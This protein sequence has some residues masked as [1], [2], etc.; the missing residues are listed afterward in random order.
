LPR[1]TAIAAYEHSFYTYEKERDMKAKRFLSVILVLIMASNMVTAVGFGNVGANNLFATDSQAYY[2]DESSGNEESMSLDSDEYDDKT[3]VD[4]EAESTEGYDTD[5]HPTSELPDDEYELPQSDDDCLYG[6]E[7]GY[8]LGLLPEC[9]CEPDDYEYIYSEFEHE[10]LRGLVTAPAR[11][12]FRPFFVYEGDTQQIIIT[13][14]N[15][16]NYFDLNQRIG[17]G[18]GGEL[19]FD[20]ETGSVTLTQDIV[21][22]VGSTTLAPRLMMTSPFRLEGEVY[23]GTRDQHTGQT[24]RGADGIGFAFHPN[25]TRALGAIGGALGIGGLPNGIGFKLDTWHNSGTPANGYLA[26]PTRFAPVAATNLAIRNAPHP[27]FDTGSLTHPSGRDQRDGRAFGAFVA[28][29]SIAFTCQTGRSMIG[30]AMV[31]DPAEGSP[32][33]A[34]GLGDVTRDSIGDWRSDNWHSI[35]IDYD[36]VNGRNIMSVY[37]ANINNPQV[38]LDQTGFANLDTFTHSWVMDITDIV[39]ASIASGVASWGLSISASTGGSRNFHGFRIR[40]VDYES[41][42]G[43]LAE[44]YFRDDDGSDEGS[45]EA[46]VLYPTITHDNVPED[47]MV[48]FAFPEREAS[49]N[50]RGY[51]FSRLNYSYNRGAPVYISGV[52]VLQPG[53]LYAEAGFP[54]YYHFHPLYNPNDINSPFERMNFNARSQPHATGTFTYYFRRAHGTITVVVT[55]TEGNVINDTFEFELRDSDGNVVLDL[56]D[57][58]IILI[59]GADGTITTPSLPTG[60]FRLYPVSQP[61]RWQIQNVPPGAID[62]SV[63]FDPLVHN[64]GGQN[65]EPNDP[66]PE[67]NV[68]VNLEYGISAPTITV[69][70][71]SDS[72]D[73]DDGVYI[74]PD[75]V[76][77]NPYEP[78][79]SVITW[80]LR[81]EDGNLV[82]QG[83]GAEIPQEVLNNLPIGDYNVRFTEVTDDGTTIYDDGEFR[84]ERDMSISIDRPISPREITADRAHPDSTISWTITTPDGIYVVSGPGDRVPSDILSNLPNGDY[85][86]AFVEITPGVDHDGTR[87]LESGD[88]I[89]RDDIFTIGRIVVEVDRPVNPGNVNAIPVYPE[90]ESTISWVIRGA[91]G[92]EVA[93]G[94]GYRIPADVLNNLLDGDYEAEFTERGLNNSEHVDT[95]I[96]SVERELSPISTP[97]PTSSPTPTPSPTPMPT[98]TPTPSSTPTPYPTH[99]PSHNSNATLTHSSTPTPRA[100]LPEAP[101]PSPDDQ[102]AYDYNNIHYS[103]MIGYDDGTIRPGA[104]VTRAQ[105]AT[106]LFR[107]MPDTRRTH[108]WA[109]ANTFTDVVINNWFNNAVSTTSNANVFKGMPD[110]NFQPNR[111]ITRGELVAA[112]VRY[113][114]INPVIGSPQFTDTAGHWAESYINAAAQQGWVTGYYGLNGLFLP[115]QPISRAET[116]ALINR[117]LQRIPQEPSDLLPDMI[118]WPDNA[119]ESTW[120]YLYIQE[121]SNSHYYVKKADGIHETWHK[122]FVPELPWVVLERPDS[123]P[124][125]IFR[126]R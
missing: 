110:G 67:T 100:Q 5:E 103:Y 69:V 10:P 51:F 70:V 60:D 72:Q 77:A 22:Q 124:E 2:Y 97:I 84:I 8:E 45:T 26:D 35:I 119:N 81:D 14:S 50:T 23:L 40:H 109:Q 93:S 17:A 73:P 48:R 96:F 57:N 89:V 115:N 112:V 52:R 76:F 117:M 47:Q 87:V 65:M 34:L 83:S 12:L 43:V 94:P 56:D 78:E 33:R 91:D 19:S 108:Y 16:L 27:G 58:P 104:A 64:N 18:T 9:I 74:N 61:G 123:R 107:L 37:F 46:V 92:N 3:I 111:E 44:R 68:I 11:R 79:S 80:V 53:A 85:R 55:D 28:T 120:Y 102:S 98:S 15:F 118:T 90:G 21:N 63:P 32:S 38:V 116:A 24:V 49:L 20:A 82:A 66:S 54:F 101:R 1:L 71:E 41:W 95:G 13:R 39:E 122:L 99:E 86:V 7:C 114:G 4:D 36:I 113:M 105:A 29:D 42:T 31:H 125:Y 88:T 59:P 6:C 75:R 126:Y 62:V 30:R 121:A 106:I 25:N